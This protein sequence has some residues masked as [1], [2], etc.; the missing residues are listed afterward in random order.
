MSIHRHLALAGLVAASLLAQQPAP[1][2]QAAPPA[3]PPARPEGRPPGLYGVIK[4]TMGDITVRLFENETPITVKNFVDLELGR[5]AWRDP[6]TGQKVFRPLYN[7]TTFHR[8]IPRFMI[9]GGDPK[10]D[11]TGDVGFTIKDEFVPS[12]NFHRPGKLAMANIGEPNTGA[13][14]FFITVAATPHLNNQHTIFGEVVEGMDVVNKIVSV[15]RDANNKP[16][17]PVRITTIAFSRE[18]AAPANDVLKPAARKAAPAKKGA[19]P[20]KSAAP[21]K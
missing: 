13:C 10:G 19:A 20:K 4:T 11:G 1:A 14:Q 7:G 6:R 15:P 12:L 5:K 17:T 8:V 16:R 3:Q 21:K 2:Q 9:Q 18:G